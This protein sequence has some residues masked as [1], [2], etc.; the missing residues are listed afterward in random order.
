LKTFK[1]YYHPKSDIKKF[2]R[3]LR[4]SVN[5]FDATKEKG[6]KEILEEKYGA[7]DD[8]SDFK[9]ERKTSLIN[10]VYNYNPSYFMDKEEKVYFK[11]DKMGILFIV[12][13]LN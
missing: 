6:I 13:I 10:A 5:N 12:Y 2:K 9:K 3:W 4:Y 8:Y 11:H 7:L 1:L